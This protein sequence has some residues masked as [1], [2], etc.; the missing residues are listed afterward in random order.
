M[1]RTACSGSAVESTI[2]ALRPPVSAISM[3][4]GAAVSASC[5]SISLATSVEPVKQTP[6]MRGSAVSGAP[7]DGPSPGRSWS[8][9]CRHAGLVQQRHRARGDQ[10]R[11]LGRLGD[12]RIAGDERGRDLAGEDRQRKIPRRDA[13]DHAARLGAGFHLR[14]FGRVV[15]QEVDR[16][17]HLG[18]AVGQRL[19]GLA[20]A[21]REELD[22]IRLVEV[23]GAPQDIR[24]LGDRAGRPHRLGFSRGANGGR[25][26]GGIGLVHRADNIGRSCR[27]DDRTTESATGRQSSAPARRRQPAPR[28]FR[29]A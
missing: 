28:L 10:R 12:H 23:G 9:S 5:R 6:A 4:S 29:Q 25:D 8:T 14:R 3:A 20:R 7:T 17:A 27:I 22:G 2:M 16:L 26:L 21:K 15:A 24:P 1:S 19:A 18:D 13:D 11:L